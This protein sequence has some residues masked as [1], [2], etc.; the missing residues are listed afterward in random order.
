MLAVLKGFFSLIPHY[1]YNLLGG[2]VVL[3]SFFP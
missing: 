2:L 1:L 3:V